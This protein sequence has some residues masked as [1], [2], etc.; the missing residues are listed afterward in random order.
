[1]RSISSLSNDLIIRQI[2][3]KI[4]TA[5][6]CVRA[7][8]ETATRNTRQMSITDNETRNYTTKHAEIQTHRET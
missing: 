6:S 4:L 2:D 3:L 1:M 7:Q 5:V 8:T